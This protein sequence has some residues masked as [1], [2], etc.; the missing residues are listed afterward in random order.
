M[1]GKDGV[2]DVLGVPL[3]LPSGGPVWLIEQGPG[4]M[5][6]RMRTAVGFSAQTQRVAFYAIDP[7]TGDP[8]LEVRPLVQVPVEMPL[9]PAISDAEAMTPASTGAARER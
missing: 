6:D 1:L 2:F 7:A 9:R 8:F 4:T 5:K 3:S